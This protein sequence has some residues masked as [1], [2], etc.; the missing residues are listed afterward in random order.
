M[1]NQ[2]IVRRDRTRFSRRT[3]LAGSSALMATVASGAAI[4]WWKRGSDPPERRVY[5]ESLYTGFSTLQSL[6][7]ESRAIVIATLDSIGTREVGLFAGDGRVVGKR[8]DAV[9]HFS[10]SEVLKGKAQVGALD[11]ISSLHAAY[12]PSL[13]ETPPQGDSPRLPL[14]V[15][16]R[17]V[18]FLNQGQGEDGIEYWRFAGDPLAATISDDGELLFVARAFYEEAL[19]RQGI[20]GARPG[21]VA[22]FAVT[23]AALRPLAAGSPDPEVV[24]PPRS[25]LPPATPVTPRTEKPTPAP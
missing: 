13:K 10:V 23:L 2:P 8:T 22:P 5:S 15:K 19:R 6:L 21:S 20:M 25:S 3:L 18:L 14:K 9:F 4:G 16:E 1:K 11:M 24:D 17:Y 12:D 7:A